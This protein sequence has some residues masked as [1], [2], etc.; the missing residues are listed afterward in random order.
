MKESEDIKRADADAQ[1]IR[2]QIKALDDQIQAETQQIA[3]QFDA[4]AP[5]DKL[6]VS[7]KRGQVTVQF[8]ALGWLPAEP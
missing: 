5:L 1:A 8:V 4:A 7:P 2:D 6:T 3:S